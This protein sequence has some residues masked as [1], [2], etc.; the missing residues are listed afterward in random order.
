MPVQNTLSV[1]TVSRYVFCTFIRTS[2]TQIL[3]TPEPSGVFRIT[4]WGHKRT[5]DQPSPRAR[6]SA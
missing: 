5:T 1:W 6:F 2:G 4:P 3:A